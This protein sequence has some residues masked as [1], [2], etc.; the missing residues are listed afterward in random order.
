MRALPL[1]VVAWLL[2]A[3][4]S[5]AAA[6]PADPALEARVQGIAAELRCLVCQNQ[7]IADSN[8]DLAVD[9]RNQ[10]RALLRQGRSEREV[11]D[12]MTARY[13]DF[14]L[15]RPPLKG[16]TWLLW[17]GPVLFLVCGLAVLALVLRQR[18]RLDP[19]AFEPD[20]ADTPDLPRPGPASR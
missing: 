11:I 5:T 4:L 20:A 6:T 14:V 17:F 3:A 18:S 7:T 15:Y 8:S 2:G 16:S 13:G 10:A 12:F 9:L 1:A 19:D